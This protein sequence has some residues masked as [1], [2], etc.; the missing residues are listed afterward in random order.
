MHMSAIKNCR[1]GYN[2]KEEK[3]EGKTILKNSNLKMGKRAEEG[4]G[5]RR[6]RNL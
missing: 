2:V 4:N 6:N 1:E 5:K 3:R